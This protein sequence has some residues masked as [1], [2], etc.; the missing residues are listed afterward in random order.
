MRSV[1]RLTILGN[2]GS[3]KAFNGCIKVSIATNRSWAENGQRQERTDWIP[4]TIF[5][6]NQR[7][8]VEEN[9]EPGDA[10]YVE[11]RVGQ[12]SYGRGE[13][14]QFTVDIIATLFNKL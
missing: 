3:I 11:A 14:R 13:E 10:V 6:E 2:V 4:V 9:V 5:D 8:W 7:K 12:S 1:N